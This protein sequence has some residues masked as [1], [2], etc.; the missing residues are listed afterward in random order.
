[1][2]VRKYN[3]HARLVAI[4]TRAA[5]RPLM[6][7]AGIDFVLPLTDL[8]WS[9]YGLSAVAPGVFT[10]VRNLT[11]TYT[12]AEHGD[13]D[14]ASWYSHYIQGAGREL[15]AVNLYPYYG[16]WAFAHVARHVYDA[17]GVVLLGLQDSPTSPL[18]ADAAYPIG[19]ADMGVIIAS[20]ISIANQ[21]SALSESSRVPL[22]DLDQIEGLPDPRSTPR[23]ASVNASPSESGSSLE[24]MSTAETGTGA[25]T[26]TVE[27]DTPH[28][29]PSSIYDE[30]TGHVIVYIRSSLLSRKEGHRLLK[31]T[32][33]SI[34]PRVDSVTLRVS[35]HASRAP[36]FVMDRVSVE[37]GVHASD[38]LVSPELLPL[39]P[40]ST[41]SAC[42]PTPP[43]RSVLILTGVECGGDAQGVLDLLAVKDHYTQRGIR[44]HAVTAL[45]DKTT[46][47]F[48]PPRAETG[49]EEP[50]MTPAFAQGE[51][52]VESLLEGVLCYAHFF[53]YVVGVCRT[54]V[55]DPDVFAT[56]L[57][58]PSAATFGDVFHSLLTHH[59]CLAL[60]I[61]RRHDN[62]IN[63]TRTGAGHGRFLWTLPPAS[64]PID[65][66]H[67]HLD[68]ILVRRMH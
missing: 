61:Y 23:D 22:N 35:G 62:T 15:Y 14:S 65:H 49:G 41:D 43:P 59:A 68:Y 46:V 32:L 18:S 53:P 8:S 34:L 67:D 17:F 11:R 64:T 28:A 39:S 42:P 27:E 33:R 20:D 37:Y 54:F 63:G 57:P 16:G 7:S 66:H 5:S 52:V 40:S 36:S 44:I 10:L 19:P 2:V 6:R 58:P 4:A 45:A 13:Y 60:A 1:M 29:I 55:R 26:G 30:G 3:S 50:Y 51:V 9:L 25:G 38:L 24:D 21:V 47:A 48:L 31:R 12:D 56:L